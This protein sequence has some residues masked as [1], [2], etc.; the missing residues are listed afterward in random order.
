VTG[1]WWRS[2]SS[3]PAR[4]LTVSGR[5]DSYSPPPFEN[6]AGTGREARGDVY[7]MKINR[8]TLAWCVLPVGALLMLIYGAAFNE[9]PVYP[10]NTVQSCP[11]SELALIEEVTFGGVELDTLGQ[12]RKTYTD[13]PLD[14]CPT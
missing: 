6:F 1:V 12:I 7:I 10:K 11:E 2:W 14:F 13:K 8:Q 5:F 4:G 9:R 3:K